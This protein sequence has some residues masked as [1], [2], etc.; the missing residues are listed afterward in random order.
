MVT[1]RARIP[2]NTDG[3]CAGKI[4]ERALTP[5]KKLTLDESDTFNVISDGISPSMTVVVSWTSAGQGPLAL[6]LF[7]RQL[8]IRTSVAKTTFEKEVDTLRSIR[9]RNVVS[10][11]GHGSCDTVNVPARLKAALLHASSHLQKKT[12]ATLDRS[13]VDFFAMPILTSA[14]AFT[15]DKR[16]SWDDGIMP[17]CLFCGM[18]QDLIIGMS[19]LLDNGILHV[20]LKLDNILVDTTGRLIIS[21]FGMVIR[22]ASRSL[23]ATF[24]VVNEVWPFGNEEHI[25]PEVHTA[26]QMA[27]REIERCG[28]RGCLDLRKQAEWSVG[29]VLWELAI[30]REPFGN[31]PRNI[32]TEKAIPPVGLVPWFQDILCGLTHPTQQERLDLHQALSLLDTPA[33][34]ND[35][36]LCSTVQA[37]K[38]AF[39]SH[40]IT[41]VIEGQSQTLLPRDVHGGGWCALLVHLLANELRSGELDTD[42]QR[43]CDESYVQTRMSDMTGLQKRLVSHVRELRSA[44]DQV[45]QAILRMAST[46][47]IDIMCGGANRWLRSGEFGNHMEIDQW[48]SLELQ[49]ESWAASPTNFTAPVILALMGNMDNRVYVLCTKQHGDLSWRTIPLRVNQAQD[50]ELVPVFFVNS[51]NPISTQADDRLQHFCLGQLAILGHGDGKLQLQPPQHQQQQQRQEPEP[52]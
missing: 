30:G 33:F 38:V 21:D 25:A 46:I 5:H 43:Y 40:S 22:R 15:E 2:T 52:A 14:A 1:D 42:P 49:A 51:L 48:S 23:L 10:Y 35:S 41:L 50:A 44:D 39:F 11:E 6:K 9:H 47:D 36:E 45:K 27:G 34:H 19:V 18:S 29:V 32:P 26:H 4:A 13:P 24:E 12:R 20:D 8:N 31:Y 16:L 28:R 17:A 3:A 37:Q 7:F